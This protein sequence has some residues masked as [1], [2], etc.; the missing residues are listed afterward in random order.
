MRQ[1]TEMKATLRR[2]DQWEIGQ[3]SNEFDAVQQ[4]YEEFSD[5]RD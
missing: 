3:H 5:D 2:D 1:F 4:R